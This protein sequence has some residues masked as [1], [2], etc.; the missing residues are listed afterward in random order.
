M[1]LYSINTE[2]ECNFSEIWKRMR[3]DSQINIW[4]PW[5]RIDIAEKA[6]LLDFIHSYTLCNGED[7]NNLSGYSSYKIPLGTDVNNM[8][9]IPEGSICMLYQN[10]IDENIIV[11]ELRAVSP[12]WRESRTLG[13]AAIG[14]TVILNESGIP[15]NYLVLHHNNPSVDYMG[16][17]GHT[18]LLRE[19]T[20]PSRRMHSS[21]VNSYADTEM[22][23]WLNGDFI[24]RLDENIL[25]YVAEV[26]LPFR[27]GSST[28]NRLISRGADGLLTRV[29]LLSRRETGME[30]HNW[31]PINE[32]VV[33]QLLANSLPINTFNDA[34]HRSNFASR[35]PDTSNITNFF[36]FFAN[37]NRWITNNAMS[38][39][40]E[41][42][43]A[44]SLPSH[45]FIHEGGSVSNQLEFNGTRDGSLEIHYR[46]KVG[47]C[48][49][50][51]TTWKTRI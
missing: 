39:I 6:Q 21:N 22:H 15:V 2:R 46:A 29:F 33:F 9:V 20:L 40:Y 19:K 50:D 4:T 1:E 32:G 48:S 51:W 17:D 18:I 38:V 30:T 44:L 27:A 34:G 23:E 24:S 41:P 8:P 7:L 28:G 13:E 47:L 35:T 3:T 11:Q 16:F 42:R 36:F 37:Q 5:R 12:V 49:T 45:F 10:R 14:S 43:P 26:R 25:N 31:E